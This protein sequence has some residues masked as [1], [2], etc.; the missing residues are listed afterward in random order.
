MSD[1][2]DINELSCLWISEI[3]KYRFS[4]RIDDLVV[5]YFTVRPSISGETLYKMLEEIL[6]ASKNP[7]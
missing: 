1:I 2:N 3:R 7:S 5:D 6:S 4:L